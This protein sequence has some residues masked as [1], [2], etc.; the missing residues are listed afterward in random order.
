MRPSAEK[1]GIVSS[2]RIAVNKIESGLARVILIVSIQPKKS[3]QR[4]K[5]CPGPKLLNVEIPV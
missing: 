2:D 3:S 4:T 5:Y 1:S